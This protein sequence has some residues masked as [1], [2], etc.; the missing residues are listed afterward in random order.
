LSDPNRPTK[1]GEVYSELYDNQWT[2]A[3]EA[4]KKAGHEEQ[5]AI[6]TLALT[7][8]VMLQIIGFIIFTCPLV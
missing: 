5:F 4:L 2:D 7:L 1:L 6:E 8:Q 3:F